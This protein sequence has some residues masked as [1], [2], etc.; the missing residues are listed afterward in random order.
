M[1]PRA[2][3]LQSK[4][5]AGAK[6]GETAASEIIR[7]LH[8]FLAAAASTEHHGRQT[9]GER[10]TAFTYCHQDISDHGETGYPAPQSDR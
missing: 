7:G 6:V 10:I 2:P 1:V 9:E 3:R 5:E 8:S 4:A